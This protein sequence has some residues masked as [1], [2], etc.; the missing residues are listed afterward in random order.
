MPKKVPTHEV[1]RAHIR[2]K[3]SGPNDWSLPTP[4]WRIAKD[5]HF[6]DEYL[7]D[8]CPEGCGHD[9]SKWY[10]FARLYVNPQFLLQFIIVFHRQR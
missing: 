5:C 6:V 9:L 10:A 4:K 2:T 3:T 7:V 1:L 8:D